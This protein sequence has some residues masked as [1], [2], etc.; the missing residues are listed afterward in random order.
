M[1][2][3]AEWNF[4][5]QSSTTSPE[6]P[7][8]ISLNLP[9]RAPPSSKP[10]SLL[11]SHPQIRTHRL[12]ES[13]EVIIPR[14]RRVSDKF[15]SQ[16]IADS[17]SSESFSRSQAS[18][19]AEAGEKNFE[20]D[21]S[22]LEI[23]MKL[24]W[25]KKLSP[26]QILEFL[27]VKSLG[28]DTIGLLGAIIAKRSSISRLELSL[29]RQIELLQ[30]FS[31]RRLEEKIKYIFK[32]AFKQIL[33]PKIDKL[34]KGLRKEEKPM[35]L[36]EFYEHHFGEVARE[37]A[38]PL[39]NFVLPGSKSIPSA[40]KTFRNEFFQN[41]KKSATFVGLLRQKLGELLRDSHSLIEEELHRFVRSIARRKRAVAGFEDLL[42][43][44][45]SKECKLPWTRLDF[46]DSIQQVTLLLELS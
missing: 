41:I 7:F 18:R 20:I 42:K 34:K 12:P 35:L 46:E 36:K 11:F 28:S 13:P 29:S 17:E 27:E 40:Y 5:A 37:N 43:Y 15:P 9:R 23:L 33:S 16:K 1:S 21:F 31:S 2:G 44:V 32:L 25:C 30:K 14:V 10:A 38:I 22:D 39:E 45:R 6:R 3:D 4:A 19:A 26:N 8:E 24:I